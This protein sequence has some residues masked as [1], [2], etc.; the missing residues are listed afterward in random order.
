MT[1]HGLW[2]AVFAG[3]A[4]WVY[5]SSPQ[6]RELASGRGSLIFPAALVLLAGAL[7]WAPALLWIGLPA[8]LGLLVATVHER[9]AIRLV[10]ALF[11][12]G[13]GLA[14]V[15]EFFYIQDAFGNRMNT[16]FKVGFQAWIFLGVAAA[17]A[18]IVVVSE[19]R[20]R[21]R[22]LAGAVLGVLVLAASPY[23]PL[24]AEDWTEMGTAT[25]TLDGAAYLE[26]YNPDEAAAIEWLA[27]V[28]SDD[29]VIVEAP[30]CAYQSLDGV[31]MN[32]ASAFTGVPALLGWANHERQWRR[33]EF[34]DLNGLDR[35]IDERDE[36]SELWLSGEPA[37]A[38]GIPAPR[39]IVFGVVERNTSE[40]CPQLVA[41]GEQ[42][43]ARLQDSGWEIAF[44]QGA[45][46]ILV[47]PGDP[48]AARDD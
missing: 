8:G 40:R 28:A 45:S 35:A 27:G 44:Q 37:D 23:A 7:A 3:F 48:L 13:F 42:E 43:I 30:G 20:A 25:G 15:P 46:T 32:R 21:Q 47:E 6:I 11:A 12:A 24:S 18:G 29:D 36:L 33:G 26:I 1:V 38:A 16:I 4:A 2:I 5:S 10:G 22:R 34:E 14:L 31:P 39:F 41:R 9:P 19:S 17:V